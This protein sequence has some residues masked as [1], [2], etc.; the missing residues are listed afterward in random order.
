MLGICNIQEFLQY[1][2]PHRVKFLF[3]FYIKFLSCKISFDMFPY[4]VKLVF[5]YILMHKGEL[6]SEYVHL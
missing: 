3:I 4:S 6:I 5:V 1:V 2:F